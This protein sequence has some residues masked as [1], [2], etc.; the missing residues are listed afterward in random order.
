MHGSPYS[1][2]HWLT[3]IWTSVNINVT[4]SINNINIVVKREY[5]QKDMLV[6]AKT[7]KYVENKS[8]IYISY[9]IHSRW[10]ELCTHTCLPKW[11]LSANAIKIIKFQHNRNN[12]FDFK[13]AWDH[14]NTALNSSSHKRYFL[15][16]SISSFVFHFFLINWFYLNFIIHTITRSPQKWPSNLWKIQIQFIHNR[17]RPFWNSQQKL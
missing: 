7:E 1:S 16:H 10:L 15:L 4:Q 13:F 17:C 6:V 3:F 8:L 12:L 11:K 14:R 2:P 9:Y 5:M